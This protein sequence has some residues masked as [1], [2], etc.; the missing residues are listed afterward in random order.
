VEVEVVGL[1]DAEEGFSF[2]RKSRYCIRRVLY[3]L[4]WVFWVEENDEFHPAQ[5]SSLKGMH[6]AVLT[7]N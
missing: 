3:S 4:V 1:N 6:H 2:S 7:W 5:V